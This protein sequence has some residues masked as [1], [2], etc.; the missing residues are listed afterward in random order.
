MTPAFPRF[1]ALRR[2]PLV[3]AALALAGLVAGCSLPRGAALQTEV[4]KQQHSDERDYQVVPVSRDNLGSVADW[5][6]TGGFAQLG[7]IGKQRGPGTLVIAADD[8][9][10]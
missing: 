9:G 4:L 5:P 1:F 7:W 3:M 6:V 2:L 8:L 10:Q